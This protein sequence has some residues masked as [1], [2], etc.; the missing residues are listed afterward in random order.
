[1]DKAQ[2]TVLTSTGG[3]VVVDNE[4]SSNNNNN[5]SM[6]RGR[7]STGDTGKSG[8][9]VGG[10]DNSND[11]G[12]SSSVLPL[13][14]QTMRPPD[15][16]V[17][18]QRVRAWHP[19][20]DPNWMVFSYLILAVV[21]IPVGYY[22]EA[23]S[24]SLIEL[25]QVYDSTDPDQ[26][27]CGIGLE[28]NA[29]K[30]CTIEFVV[31]KTMTPPIMVHYELNNF[32]QNHRKYFESQDIYQMAGESDISKQFSTSATACQPINILGDTVINPCG[33]I[34]NTFFNDVITLSEDNGSVDDQ[35]SALKMREDGI[36]WTSDLEYRYKMPNGYMQSECT[37]E[38]GG[39]TI[40]CCQFYN[41]TC[42]IDNKGPAIDRKTGK[43]YA[44]SYPN[45]DTT[46][47][48][49]E[50]Y[51]DIISPLEHVTNEHFV[52]WMRIATR[53]SFR[54][55]YGYFEQTIPAGTVLSFNIKANY[56]V[57]SF[58]G[59]KAL[60]VSTSNAWGGKT[61]VAGVTLYSI[62]YFCLACGLFFATK[63]WFKPRRVA[64]KKYLHYKEHAD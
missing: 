19:I 17:Q 26:Q 44:Y 64:D 18:Q 1:M 52:V 54:K 29:N 55:L 12:E 4:N 49:Y 30:T 24:E 57:E 53:Q 62:G 25:Y 31:P 2:E 41:Y 51:P 40:G 45:D 13:D 43:C 58:Q 21:M 15:R 37:N 34:A 7:A 28:Y 36:A 42:Q 20:L 39:C 8:N 56:V 3:V 59:S 14:E 35:G 48:L 22:L 6:G 61:K 38:Q 33:L 11:D 50:T 10:G 9:G 46:Q 5:N 23:S 32:H 47:Y 27:L 60:V 16:A 63:H